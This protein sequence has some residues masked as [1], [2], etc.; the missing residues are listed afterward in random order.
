MSLLPGY[1]FGC[2]V[3][4]NMVFARNF[5]LSIMVA[6]QLRQA[7][8]RNKQKGHFTRCGLACSCGMPILDG[9]DVS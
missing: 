3:D 4:P 1:M 6:G 7:T 5:A 8:N 9:H 2:S